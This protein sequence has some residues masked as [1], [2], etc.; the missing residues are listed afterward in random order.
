MENG[1]NT[2]DN[3]MNEANNVNMGNTEAVVTNHNNLDTVDA[4]KRSSTT[5]KKN[6]ETKDVVTKYSRTESVLKQ[7]DNTSEHKT[8]DSSQYTASVNE[9]L[10]GK[11]DNRCDA[12]IR[13]V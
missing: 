1:S 10:N 12:N 4:L 7:S 8:I 5:T 6:S 3:K 11:C 13:A 2:T 9:S